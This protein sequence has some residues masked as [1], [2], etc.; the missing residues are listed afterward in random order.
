MEFTEEQVICIWIKSQQTDDVKTNVSSS[1]KW[2]LHNV[3]IYKEKSL[4]RHCNDTVMTHSFRIGSTKST[5]V[6]Y[7]KRMEIAVGER[8]AE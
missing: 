4:C 6:C 8:F 3:E 2:H 1:R 5:M 7:P